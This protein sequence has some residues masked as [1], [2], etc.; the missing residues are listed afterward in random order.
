LRERRRFVRLPG[1]S[2]QIAFGTYR[3]RPEL[4]G[5]RAN[6]VHVLTLRGGEIADVTCFLDPATRRAFD[7]PESLPG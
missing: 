5:W 7:V 1:A 4:G 3:W 2:G 6:A